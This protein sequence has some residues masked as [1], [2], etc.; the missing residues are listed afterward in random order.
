MTEKFITTEKG[1]AM[2][3][4]YEIVSAFF[5]QSWWIMLLLGGIHSS[6][7]HVPAIGYWTTG[8][9]LAIFYFLSCFFAGAGAITRAQ[10]EE[11][12]TI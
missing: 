6:L 11:K 10:L 4:I 1:Q 2:S 5:L 3:R 8:M 12:G 9:F 7:P